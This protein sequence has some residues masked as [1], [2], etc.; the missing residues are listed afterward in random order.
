MPIAFS[1]NDGV[2]PEGTKIEFT[3]AGV[4]GR[5]LTVFDQLNP[6]YAK[7]YTEEEAG[8]LMKRAGFADVRLHHRHGYSWTVLGR[9]PEHGA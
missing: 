6:S 1:P 9:K 3:V 7:Y 4:Q 2:Q 5:Y 8:Q